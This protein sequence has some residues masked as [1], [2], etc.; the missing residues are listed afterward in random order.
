[1]NMDLVK[2][3]GDYLSGIAPEAIIRYGDY[4]RGGSTLKITVILS[5]LS[6]VAK[7]KAYYDRMPDL[8]AEQQKKDEENEAKLKELVHASAAVPSLFTGNGS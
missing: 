6:S 5:Q 4:P 1:M 2:E 3:L 7:V 8:L